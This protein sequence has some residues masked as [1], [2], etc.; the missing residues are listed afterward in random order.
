MNAD[1]SVRPSFAA[2]AAAI[3]QIQAAS[4]LRNYPQLPVEIAEHINENTFTEQ[5]LAAID[6][7]PSARHQVFTALEGPTIVGFAALSPVNEETGQIVAFEVAPDYVRHGHGARLLAACVDT[8]RL[9]NAQYVRTWIIPDDEPRV[10]FFTSAGF[11]L[12]GRTRTLEGGIVE[13]A[14]TANIQES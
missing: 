3:A 14:Y 10:R 8:L 4:W 12:L 9:A 5:W 2:D 1:V 7:P 11:G 6:D 13:T